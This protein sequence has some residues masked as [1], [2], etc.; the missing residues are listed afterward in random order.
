MC[1]KLLPCRSTL[2]ADA[3]TVPIDTATTQGGPQGPPTTTISAGP[4]TYTYTTT[5]AAG[6][7]IAVPDVFTP[8][9][10]RLLC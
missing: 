8:T 1:L 5:N 4:T 9:V 7:T 6:A 3:T 2:L 10:V